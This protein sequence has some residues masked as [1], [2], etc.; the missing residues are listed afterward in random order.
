M[1]SVGVLATLE[2]FVDC[3]E[4]CGVVPHELLCAH[5]PREPVEAPVLAEEGGRSP[6]E[7]LKHSISPSW[8]TALHVFQRT[9]CKMKAYGHSLHKYI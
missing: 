5:T 2:A 1:S 9:L 4:D 6:H 7:S 3:P 8:H